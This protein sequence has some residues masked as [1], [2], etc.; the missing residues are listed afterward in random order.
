MNLRVEMRL[1]MKENLNKL[2]EVYFLMH[3]NTF[4]CLI[5]LITARTRN[6]HIIKP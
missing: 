3:I 4:L 6:D 2:I 5:H 1:L